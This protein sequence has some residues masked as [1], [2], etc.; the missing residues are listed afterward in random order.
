MNIPLI[1]VIGY[2]IL[3]LGI[4]WYS[5]RLSKASGVLGY[6]LAGRGLPVILVAVMITGIAVGGASTVGVAEQAYTHGISAGMYNAAWGIAAILVGLIAASRFRKMDITTIPEL[7]ERYYG[8]TGQIVAVTG[9]VIILMIIISLQYVAGGA[10]LTAL[11]PEYFTFST[12]MITTAA[13]FVG[14]TLIGGYWAA[15]LSNLINVV[16]IYI[17]II[18]GVVMS[19]T[20]SG[21]LSNITAQLPAGTPWFDPVAGVGWVM[22]IAWFLVMFPTVYS[23]QGVVQVSFAAKDAK[24]AKTGYILGGL[25]ILPV[26]FISAIF[27]IVAAAKFPG[28]ENASMALPEV[29]LSINPYIAGITLAGLWAADVSTAVGLLLGCATLV[30]KDIWKAY[31]QPGIPKKQELVIS[32]ITV[33]GISIITYL[34]ATTVEGILKTLLISLT[35]MTSYTVILFFSMFL[36]KLCRKS[37]AVWTLIAG[38]ALL[39]LWQFVPAVRI[40]PHPIY[41]EWP[42]CIITFLLIYLIDKR[43]AKILNKKT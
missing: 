10:I 15:G 27:G 20:G 17:G 35:L 21:G 18:A 43:P 24:T 36:P 33:L 1:I 16:I 5:T 28:L 9:Q 22:I 13:V 29:V 6:L 42:V 2:I 4:S 40:V 41:L 7:F 38:I 37:A 12:G 14:I 39:A 11:L 25:L 19:V 3:Q 32:R 31:L 26:G 30:V 8:K 23:T 34:L